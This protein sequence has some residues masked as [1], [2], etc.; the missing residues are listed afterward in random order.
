MSIETDEA[1]AVATPRSPENP[2]LSDAA[3]V[4]RASAIS[5]QPVADRTLVERGII[6]LSVLAIAYLSFQILT[7]GYGR[8]QGIY[9]MVA[10]SMLRGGMPYRDAWDFKPPGIFLVFALSRLLFGPSQIW[11]RVLEVL[12]LLAM[13]FAIVRLCERF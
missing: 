11:I 3:L 10:D 5:T 1:A 7:F 8:D 2:R 13:C 6:G 12:G 4:S 9:S